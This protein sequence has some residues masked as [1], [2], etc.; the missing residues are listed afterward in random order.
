MRTHY[1]DFWEYKE[2]FRKEGLIKNSHLIKESSHQ[3]PL[4]ESVLNYI[5]RMYNPLDSDKIPRVRYKISEYGLW[6]LVLSPM[7]FVSH[8]LD[9]LAGNGYPTVEPLDGKF[10]DIVTHAVRIPAFLG[11]NMDPGS[12]N[13]GYVERIKPEKIITAPERLRQ[14]IEKIYKQI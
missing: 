3:R 4:H 11:D 10:I 1:Q 5:E 6:R 8:Q 2:R 12:S 7:N 13:S 9:G 14:M